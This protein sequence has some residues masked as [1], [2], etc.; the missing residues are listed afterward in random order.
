LK[1]L[2]FAALTAAIVA[3]LAGKANSIATIFSLDIYKKFINKDATDKQVV[4]NGRYVVLGSFAIALAL[5][6]L[7]KNFG[8]GFTYIQEYTG[9]VSPGIFTIFILG[10][11]WRRATAK[12]AL[13]AA[14]LSIPLSA[15]LK[16]A[17]PDMPFLIRMGW[18]FLA[19]V[20]VMILFAYLEKNKDNSKGLIVDTSLFKPKGTFALGIAFVTVV[21]IILY[22][23][24][25]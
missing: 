24:F 22:S 19:C 11:F 2:A 18:V 9:F 21:L 20:A 3:S 10:F 1:G 5:S 25:W 16:F 7:L 6:P 23:V 15:L 4:M 8:Q 13:A 12:G 17:I 14:L